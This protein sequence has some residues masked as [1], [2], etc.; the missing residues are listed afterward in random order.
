M[1]GL[2]TIISKCKYSVTLSINEHRDSYCSLEDYLEAINY[3]EDIKKDVLD[4][5]IELDRMVML[6]FYPDT[7]VGF[8]VIIHHDINEAIRLALL[9]LKD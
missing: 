9:E 1:D 6:Q 3:K 5:M 4:K 2:E 8:F 7:P